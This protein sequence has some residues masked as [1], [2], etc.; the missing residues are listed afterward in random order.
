MTDEDRIAELMASWQR[1][2]ADADVQQLLP[3][4][5]EDVVFLAAGQPRLS[6]REAFVEHLRA[7]LGSV[8]LEPSSEVREIR[9]AG[10]LAYCWSDVVLRVTPLQP[11]PVLRLVGP[12]LT[13][14]R[15]EPHGRWVVFRA[16]SML[17][18]EEARAEA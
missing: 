2:V 17:V 8:R 14:L 12:D 7:A 10:D 5:A 13:I 6:G 18:P 16:A 9:I 4:M 1:A 3:L 15:R 11:A